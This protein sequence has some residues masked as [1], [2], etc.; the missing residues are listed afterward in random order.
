MTHTTSSLTHEFS[1]IE[2]KNKA[3]AMFSLRFTG[4]GDLPADVVSDRPPSLNVMASVPRAYDE[5]SGANIV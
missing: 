5:N 3:G 4:R 1:A 2:W